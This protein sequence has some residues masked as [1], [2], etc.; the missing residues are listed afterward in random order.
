MHG[1][2]NSPSVYSEVQIPC[3]TLS[4]LDPTDTEKSTRGPTFNNSAGAGLSGKEQ[5]VNHCNC[6][7]WNGRNLVVCIDGTSNQFGVKNTNVIELYRLVKKF[8]DEN[9]LTYYNSGI[10]TYAKPSWKSLSYMKQVVDHKIDLAIAW[11]FESIVISA[12]RWLSENYNKGDRIFLFGFSRGAYQVRTLAAMIDKVGLIHKGN[13]EQIPFAYELYAA[14][15]PESR[16]GKPKRNVGKSKKGSGKHECKWKCKPWAKTKTTRVIE[17]DGATAEHTGGTKDTAKHF[18][19]T[20]SRRV[21]VHF[22]GVWDTVSSVGVVRHKVL[23]GTADGMKHVCSFRHALALDERR[24]KFL[25][26]YVN[27]GLSV[28]NARPSDPADSGKAGSSSGL[29]PSGNTQPQPPHTKEV[30]FVGTHSDIG[31]GIVNNEAMNRRTASL[32][33][34]VYQAIAAGLLLDMLNEGIKEDEA[35]ETDPEVHESLTGVWW[36]LEWLPI[37]H[38]S[39]KSKAGTLRWPHAGDPRELKGGQMIHSTVLATLRRD[40]RTEPK[41]YKPKANAPWDWA[42]VDEWGKEDPR[43]EQDPYELVQRALEQCAMNLNELAQSEDPA[44]HEPLKHLAQWLWT[45]EGCRALRDRDAPK[46]LLSEADKA[47]AKL[48]EKNISALVAIIIRIGPASLGVS[49]Q[50][51]PRLKFL[52]RK[53]SGWSLLRQLLLRPHHV[54]S[55]KEYRKITRACD[56]VCT[57]ADRA[58]DVNVDYEVGERAGVRTAMS[59]NGR[60]S[61]SVYFPMQMSNSACAQDYRTRNVLAPFAQQTLCIFQ[62]FPAPHALVDASRLV[63]NAFH[64]WSNTPALIRRAS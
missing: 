42:K 26:E 2:R 60:Y 34:M 35:K 48:T 57:G 50:E 61:L 64:D 14:D 56:Y 49:I 15:Q 45:E 43:L 16:D 5:D 18:K 12:Y 27:Q 23:P 53:D 40:N 11:N 32:R 28:E 31:G 19:D 59:G 55:L 52:L 37:K 46:Y 51:I 13:E 29:R 20:F 21:Q 17:G 22:V 6:P 44:E 1:Q 8:P 10:G 54:Q 25:P 30:W 36:L 38:L 3:V 41:S 58:R 4:Q 63:L 47:A 24:V 33:W 9:Q 62:H 7:A 39:Y